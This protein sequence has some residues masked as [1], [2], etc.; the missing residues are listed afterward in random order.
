MAENN[1]S[2]DEKIYQP[3]EVDLTE[4]FE[5]QDIDLIIETFGSVC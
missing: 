3:E 4:A 5:N 2:E 1:R